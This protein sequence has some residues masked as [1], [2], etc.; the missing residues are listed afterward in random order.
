LNPPNANFYV[1]APLVDG[2]IGLSDQSLDQT[3]SFF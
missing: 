2:E 1:G 3:P